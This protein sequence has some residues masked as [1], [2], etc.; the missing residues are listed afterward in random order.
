[1]SELSTFAKKAIV[2]L[3][4]DANLEEAGG[5]NEEAGGQ[6]DS[7][8]SEDSNDEELKRFFNAEEI[9]AETFQTY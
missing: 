9:E 3:S 4:D 6:E 8:D 7:S 5:Q 1:M 2:L